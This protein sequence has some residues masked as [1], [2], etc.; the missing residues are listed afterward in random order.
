M[1]HCDAFIDAEA[2]DLVEHRHV[3]HIGRIAAE[4][5][6]R[7]DD[8]DRHAAAFHRT[9]LHGR[10]LRTQ[11]KTVGR[12]KRVLRFAGRMAFGNV[13]CVKIVIVLSPWYVFI[14]IAHRDKDIL[15]LLT[16]VIMS[17]GTAFACA[18]A[19][20]GASRCFSSN[21]CV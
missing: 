20:D 5:L 11:G 17:G 14:R 8:A 12:V 10:G 9:D 15:D 6:A 13:Q 1:G 21:L 7:S 16:H 19:G 2:L 18:A 4:N 3:R